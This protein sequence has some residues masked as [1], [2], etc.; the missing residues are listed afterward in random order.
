MS[1]AP[2]KV[3]DVVTDEVDASPLLRRNSNTAPRPQKTA[4]LV[5]QSIFAQIT[6]RRMKAGEMLPPERDMLVE[7]AVGR[8][9]LREALRFLEMQGVITIRP[10]PGGGPVVSVPD[11]RYLAGTLSMML[12]FARTPFRAIVETR[13]VIEPAVAAAA[14]TRADSKRVEEIRRSVERMTAQ[15]GHVDVFLEEN[16]RFHD[17]I[18]WSSGNTVFGYLLAALH[19]INDGTALGVQYPEWAQKVVAKA[20]Q[21]IYDAIAA[22]DAEQAR[23]SMS[24][25]T[26]QYQRYLE[27]HYAP[28]LDQLVKW[29]RL[30]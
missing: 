26:S 2:T 15:I 5:A 14:A 23:T 29:N 7:Y 17:L 18:A 4:A 24:A 30:A 13:V 22:H 21:R 16:V 6:A 9:T 19:W 8:G 12:Q 28:L 3:P 10:G 25:H 20:H 27:E 11:S 1:E